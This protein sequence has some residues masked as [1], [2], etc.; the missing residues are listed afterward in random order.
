M[1][2]KEKILDVA[3]EMF[4]VHGY[5]GVSVRDI[6]QAVGANVASINY[7]FN[8]KR[9]LY[10][11]VFKRKLKK[12]SSD[13]AEDLNK[14]FAGKEPTLEEVIRN[15][16]SI[17]LNDFLSSD[18]SM[19]LL[20][21]LS[22]EMSENGVARD[23]FLKESIL[24]MHKIFRTSIQKAHPDLTDEKVVLCISSIFGQI[25]HFVRAK[26]VIRHTV[27]REYDKA[28]IAELID[29]IT[30]FSVKGIRG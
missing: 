14:A 10:R 28:F 1:G 29:H 2:T 7:H 3:E 30:D 12:L 15:I 25:F 18:E 22:D 8:S 9:E 16:V 17:F 11:S 6:T 13:R 20:T 5:D 24:P 26:A 27:G 4:L 21:I 23:I 19:K